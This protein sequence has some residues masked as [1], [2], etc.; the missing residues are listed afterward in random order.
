MARAPRERV[1]ARSARCSECVQ[2][3]ESFRP[4]PTRTRNFGHPASPTKNCRFWAA[5]FGPL[6]V[7]RGGSGW[8]WAAPGGSGWLLVALEWLRVAPGVLRVARN[9]AQGRLQSWSASRE[10]LWRVPL[11]RRTRHFIYFVCF[12]MILNVSYAFPMIFLWNL[13]V[14]LRCSYDFDKLF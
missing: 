4:D 14:V 1:V 3:V 13:Y 5:S 12:P 11:G 10:P 9:V 2:K 6:R 7:A 8:L